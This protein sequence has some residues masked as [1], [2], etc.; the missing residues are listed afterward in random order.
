VMG[1]LKKLGNPM[2]PRVNDYGSPYVAESN[3]F[4]RSERRIVLRLFILRYLS[5]LPPVRGL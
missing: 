1:F 5:H 4:A 2:T 3:Q